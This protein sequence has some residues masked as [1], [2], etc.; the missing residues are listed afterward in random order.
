MDKTEIRNV[1]HKYVNKSK[2][3]HV[4]HDI[5]FNVASSEIITLLGPSGC[6]KTTLLR[7]ISGLLS[8]EKG[9]ICINGF[10][11]FDAKKRKLIGFAFQEHALLKW[12]NVTENIALPNFIGSNNFLCEEEL[13]DRIEYLLNLTGLKK[14]SEYYPEQLSGGMKQRASLARTLLLSPK[15]FLL[16]EPFGSIDLITRTKL[17]LELYDIISELKIPTILVTHSIEEAVFLSSRIH[18][19]SNIPAQIFETLEINLSNAR[20]ISLFEN[21]EYLELCS[22]CRKILFEGGTINEI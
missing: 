14:Y 8:P 10:S 3:L 22:H 19:F 20:D 2:T 1:S 6:G 15:L 18:L 13:N 21:K 9:L 17:I 16:D 11:P 7:I 5:S 12:K 4:L